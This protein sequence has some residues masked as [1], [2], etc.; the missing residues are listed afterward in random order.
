VHA[1]TH[2]AHGL[3]DCNNGVW[4][5]KN[6]ASPSAALFELSHHISSSSLSLSFSLEVYIDYLSHL[7]SH[8]IFLFQQYQVNKERKSQDSFGLPNT[9]NMFAMSPHVYTYPAQAPPPPPRQYSGHGTSSAFSP[10]ANPDE[11]WTKISDLAERRRIQNRI[12]QRNYRT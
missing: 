3:K 5:F 4:T 10:S 12:A 2:H 1:S 9:F 8:L 6:R 11:D 7:N